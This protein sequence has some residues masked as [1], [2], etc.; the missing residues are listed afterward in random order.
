ML[1]D[2]CEPTQGA[3]VQH[4]DS[5]LKVKI[6]E[7]ENAQSTPVRTV[8][9]M[10]PWNQAKACAA[11]YK[12]ELQIMAEDLRNNPQWNACLVECSLNGVPIATSLRIEDPVRSSKVPQAETPFGRGYYGFTRCNHNDPLDADG[13]GVN[14]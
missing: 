4:G 14:A 5:Y 10:S 7:L 3:A 2:R 6:R 13:R 9:D 11:R 8:V 1:D 12:R